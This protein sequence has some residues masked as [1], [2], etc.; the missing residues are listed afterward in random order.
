V[1]GILPVRD[2]SSSEIVQSIQ[3]ILATGLAQRQRSLD[4][5]EASATGGAEAVLA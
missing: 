5:P 4:E 1:R 2:C 3:I